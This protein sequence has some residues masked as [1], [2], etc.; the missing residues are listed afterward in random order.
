MFIHV[1]PTVLLLNMEGF[2]CNLTPSLNEWFNYTPS[3][4]KK[5][6]KKESQISLDLALA[7]ATSPLQQQV[8]KGTKQKTFI[9]KIFCLTKQLCWNFRLTDRRATVP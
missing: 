2:V 7:E 6:T 1:V 4:K 5:P 3:L 8:S 9:Y